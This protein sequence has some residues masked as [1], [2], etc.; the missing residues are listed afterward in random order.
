MATN[1]PPDLP[2]LPPI[3]ESA[4]NVLPRLPRDMQGGGWEV[5][6]NTPVKEPTADAA[7]EEPPAEP[8][9]QQRRGRRDRRD[10]SAATGPSAE[11]SVAE[12]QSRRRREQR[13]AAERP[14][15]NPT[16]EVAPDGRR[17]PRTDDG[18]RF[19]SAG[20][21]LVVALLAL[22]FGALLTAPGMHKTSFNKQPG[23][24]RDI[25][26][27]VT[28]GVAGVSS[29]L[30]LDRPRHLVQSVAG[31]SRADEID[32][33]I[34]IP[35]EPTKS[36][37]PKPDS[38]KPPVKTKFTPTKK[39]RLWVAG[40]SLVITPGYSIVR[41]A[42]ASPVIDSVGGV[43]GHVATGLTRPD[44]FN[45]FEEI[46]AQMKGLRPHVVVLNFGANDDH[47]YMTG[48]DEGTTIGEFGGPDWVKEYR[49]RA[50]SVMDTI[51]R[52]GG[53]VVWIG[54]PITRSETQTQRFDQINAVVQR[55]AKARPG[56][57]IFIDT[58][59]MFAG[60]TGGFTEYLQNAKGD[61][62]KVR[63]GDGVHFDTA[64]GD[65]I[66]REV[67][68]QLNRTFDLTSWRRASN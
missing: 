53:I 22:L 65:I 66:A 60:D 15:R 49:R 63:A 31:R 42:G 16:A 51:N 35:T 14:S 4:E 59:T 11:E 39:L 13:V 46:R 17:R 48:L 41:A 6:A 47:G 24:G 32:V 33:A 28:G 3:R 43:D 52:A 58:Y 9:Q 56:K 36:P 27:A 45:W 5:V 30:Q 21:G 40:D 64:G 19:S 12:P 8:Q 1:D 10:Q 25:A 2:K 37:T 50:A 55:V 67:L 57:A 34:V 54:L 29:A 68:K 23:T 20:N 61:T 38:Q 26:L 7:A 62:V 44:V 18:R